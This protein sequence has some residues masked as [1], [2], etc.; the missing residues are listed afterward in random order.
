MSLKA[1]LYMSFFVM[2]AFTVIIGGASLYQFYTTTERLKPTEEQVNYVD[3]EL[4]PETNL[5][6]QITNHI[7]S[8]GLYFYAYALNKNIYQFEQGTKFLA[9]AM[10]EI[11]GVDEI[12]AKAAPDKLPLAR[13]TVPGLKAQL[14]DVSAKSKQL[15]TLI[16][17]L[18]P[19]YAK[20]E[21]YMAEI[22]RELD[23]VL[24]ECVADVETAL[25]D[26]KMK[27]YD[28][29]HPTAQRRVNRIRFLDELTDA[30]NAAEVIYMRARS[31][32]GKEAE[33]AYADVIGMVNAAAD[34]VDAYANSPAIGSRAETKQTFMTMVGS[35][36]G[37][38]QTSQQLASATRDMDNLS[39]QINKISV[40]ARTA[41]TNLLVS[42]ND[43]VLKQTDS[44]SEAVTQIDH[45]L[46]NATILALVL[47]AVGIV[48]GVIFAY[49]ITRG[50]TLPV[51][52]VIE[53]LTSSEKALSDASV[54]IDSAAH[55]LA[56]GANS[57]AASIEETSSAMEQMASMTRQNADNAIQTNDK[58]K[59]TAN[60]VAEGSS[61]M[62]RM[63][64]AMAEISEK[65]DKIS[66]I[67]KTIEDIAFQTN[68]LALNAAVEAARAG[69]AGKGFAVVA[70][71]VRNLSQR[72]ATAARDTS[73]LITSTVES[74]QTG[75]EIAGQ[76]S[77][78]FENIQKGTTDISHLIEQI[79]S[80]TD[81][82]AQ[83]VDQV[84]TAIAQMDKVTQSNSANASS[85]AQSASDLKTQV[86]ELRADIGSLFS[87][88]Y[89]T[90]A[91]MPTSGL[92]AGAAPARRAPAEAYYGATT[93]SKALPG[94]S[95]GG[96]KVVMHP[97]SII[98]LDGDF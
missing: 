10:K 74:V 12:M 44:I 5:F 64:A 14:V 56:E 95:A 20:A 93:S 83:G 52:A 38:A 3:H 89:G 21:S 6:S 9:D 96:E 24:A 84:N 57:Q 49:F 55:D 87:I 61:A 35:L 41:W 78:E 18:P 73:E 81:E 4:I 65:A 77:S 42:T 33:S 62:G 72:S 58:T 46:S 59:N 91:Q 7:T 48:T 82:Q 85:T 28:G 36:R 11:G 90:H 2:I 45:S 47:L 54:T 80:A 51:A 68:L 97:E 34:K 92:G 37:F 25:K 1:K 40:D 30:I 39:G 13:R 27:E 29:I 43:A 19:L 8:A 60:L 53:R 63:N 32:S 98:P 86:L 66:Q 71:E 88:I 23:G 31:L 76:L 69:E 16:E 94:P 26:P 67:I 70:D 17:G 79:A 75:N 22:G 50:I 15:E